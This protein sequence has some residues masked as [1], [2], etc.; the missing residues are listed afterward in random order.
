MAMNVPNGF[1]FGKHISKVLLSK[2]TI[3]FEI[4]PF[5]LMHKIF[6]TER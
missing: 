4:M 3:L 2:E 6:D 1:I 5:D